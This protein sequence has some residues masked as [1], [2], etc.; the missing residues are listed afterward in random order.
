MTENRNRPRN[1]FYSER[2][3]ES[4]PSDLLRKEQDYRHQWQDKYLRSNTLSFRLGQIFGLI[5]NLALLYLVYDLIQDGEKNLA[6]KIFLSNIAI[7]AFALL[8]TSVERKIISRKPPRRMR[9]DKRPTTRNPNQNRNRDNRD[10]DF[11]EKTR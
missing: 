5:Y 3:Q 6:L 7:I 8:V 2:N 9:N 10:R 1:D 11:R 4:V